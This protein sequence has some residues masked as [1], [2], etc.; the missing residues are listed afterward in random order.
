MNM[1]HEY[2][3]S[4]QARS[5][6]WRCQA[7]DLLCP[8]SSPCNGYCRRHFSLMNNPSLWIS[9]GSWESR[10]AARRHTPPTA[11]WR[12]CWSWCTLRCL[13]QMDLSGTYCTCTDCTAASAGQQSARHRQTIAEELI[14]HLLNAETHP[15]RKFRQNQTEWHNQRSYYLI[16]RHKRRDGVVI[17]CEFFQVTLF[18][19][20][21]RTIQ[22]RI[23][24]FFEP[25][26]LN[27]LTLW[28]FTL[29]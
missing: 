18:I 4:E 10:F 13:Q 19:W 2:R 12:W 22:A 11:P 15:A 24:F 26:L 29:C 27:P 25:V 17:V 7:P 1:R 28:S 16:A 5:D 8:R 23:L 14:L 9:S 6:H 20:E 21:N 3:F